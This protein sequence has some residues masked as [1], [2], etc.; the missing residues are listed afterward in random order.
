MV[1][2]TEYPSDAHMAKPPLDNPQIKCKLL[3]SIKF[4]WK[5]VN[6]K[7]QTIVILVVYDLVVIGNLHIS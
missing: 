7:A 1:L 3:V 5:F 2:I 6:Y 4:I